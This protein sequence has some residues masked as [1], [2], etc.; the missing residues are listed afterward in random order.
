MGML[1]LQKDCWEY[2]K[3][4]DYC[5]DAK[6]TTILKKWNGIL[7]RPAFVSLCEKPPCA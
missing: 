7:K 6:E 3:K 4:D 1:L 5:E 2:F